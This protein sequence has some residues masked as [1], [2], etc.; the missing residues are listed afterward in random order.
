MRILFVIDQL[1][2]A[3]NGTVMSTR[4]FAA[5]LRKMGNEVRFVSTGEEAEDKYIVGELYL[6][7]FNGIIKKQGMMLAS[8]N[9]KVLRKAIGWADVVHFLMPFWLAFEGQ[10]I[11]EKM[12]IPCTAT[13]H[14]QPENLSYSLGFGRNFLINTLID[15]VFKKFYNHFQYVHC[16]SSFI[17]TELRQKGY[18]SNFHVIS[19]GVIDG[20]VYRKQAKPPSAKKFII[21]MIGRL[22][23][24]KRQDVLIDAVKKSRH[25]G[26]IQLVL[27]GIG[28]KRKKYEKM[29]N[30]LKNPAI[31]QFF[32]QEG[33]KDLLASSDLYVHASDAEIEGI[34]CIEAFSSGLVPVISD[35]AKSATSQFAMDKRSLFKNGSSDDLA[36]K[37]DYWLDHEKERREMEITY[38]EY[39]KQFRIE[40]CVKKFEE[41]LREAVLSEKK[42]HPAALKESK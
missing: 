13:F 23:N 34:S 11:A 9:K 39:G 42:K 17:A 8:P 35:S 15:K 41:M 26:D 31:I 1:D 19:N 5:I 16:P 28:P 2:N 22:S 29:G 18:R 37:I 38:A 32:D 3:N 6:P 36:Q 24:E 7:F 30:K 40:P 21:V 12:G 20:F 4:R 27:A 14:I 33:L 25:S 10:R